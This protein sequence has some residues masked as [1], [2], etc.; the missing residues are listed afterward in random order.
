MAWFK[1]YAG[2]G[3]GFGGANY[4]DTCEFDNEGQALEAAYQAAIEIYQSY[5]GE[6]GL[7]NWNDCYDNLAESYG[8]E[9]TEEEVND[10]YGEEIESWISYYIDPATGP[11]D[12]EED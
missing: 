4:I 10:Y 8:Y 3:G 12:K 7:L 11:D 6:Y 5:E 1:I 9:P 2:L